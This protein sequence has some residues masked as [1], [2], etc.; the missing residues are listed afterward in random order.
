MECLSFLLRPIQQL[1]LMGKTGF[2]SFGLLTTTSY[3]IANPLTAQVGQDGANGLRCNYKPYIR[4]GTMYAV[5]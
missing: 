1:D 5:G 4:V 2:I 3:N